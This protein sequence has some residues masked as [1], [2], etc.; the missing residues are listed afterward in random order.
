MSQRVSRRERRRRQRERNGPYLTREEYTLAKAA[1]LFQMTSGKYA[2]IDRKLDDT[3]K[4]IDS[5]A[6]ISKIGSD[7]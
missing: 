6:P 2:E 1:E 7:S 5:L 3:I 4:L